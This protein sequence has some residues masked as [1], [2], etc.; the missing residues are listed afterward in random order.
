MLNRLLP[1]LA[2]LGLTLALTSGASAYEQT[3]PPTAPGEIQLKELPQALA[4]EAPDGDD[5]GF[6]A[7]FN[8]IQSN[9]LAMTVPV[10]VDLSDEREAMRFF[11]PSARLESPPPSADG[12]QVKALPPRTVVSLGHRGRGG[13]RQRGQDIVTLQRWIAENPEWRA[14]GAP[15]AVY[16]DGPFTPFFLRRSEVM[17][18]LSP[19][20]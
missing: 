7:L 6:R 5:E 15:I 18:E 16:W 1:V 3:Y 4:L 10:E 9:E 2:A 8:F 17:I 19:A 12:V 11:A 13:D 20:G 14:I